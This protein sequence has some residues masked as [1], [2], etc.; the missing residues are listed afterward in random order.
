MNAG[1]DVTEDFEA[2]H[3]S[4]AWKQL[5]AY[6][7]GELGSAADESD[8]TEISFIYANKTEDDVLLKYTLD[9]LEREHPKRF[10]VHYMISKETWPAERKTGAEWSSDRVEYGRVSLPVIRARGFPANGTSHVA[11]MCGPPAFEEDTCVP[12]L[13]ELGY[14]KEAIIRY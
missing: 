1:E 6:Y 9:R 3:S 8:E 11:V 2:V 14:P 12:A 4:K 10:R 7:V 5:E 13:L